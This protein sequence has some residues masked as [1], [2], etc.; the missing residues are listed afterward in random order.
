MAR[1]TNYGDNP[2]ST[3]LPPLANESSTESAVRYLREAK[4]KKRSHAIDMELRKEKEM[5]MRTRKNLLK[6]VLIGESES[7]RTTM[8]SHLRMKYAREQWDAEMAKWKSVIQLRILKAVVIILD[9]LRCELDDGAPPKSTNDTHLNRASG[10]PFD[11]SFSLGPDLS[12]KFESSSS[13]EDLPTSTGEDGGNQDTH[14]LPLFHLATLSSTFESEKE[15]ERATEVIARCGGDIK[16]LWMDEMVKSVLRK[17]KIELEES[18]QIFLEDIDRIASYNYAPSDEDVALVCSRTG[19][20]EYQIQL[21]Q[22]V[23][24]DGLTTEHYMGLYD[25]GSWRMARHAWMPFFEG[26]HAVIFF[27]SLS[28]F[29]QRSLQDPKVNR[30]EDSFIHWR[31][32]CESRLLKRSNLILFL[33]KCDVLRRKLQA[34]VKVKDYVPSYGDRP[35]HFDMVVKY[36]Q[37]PFTQIAKVYSDKKCFRQV[38]CLV[39]S[40][41]TTDAGLAIF[42]VKD[43]V[44]RGYL[45]KGNLL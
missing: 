27:A 29:D 42:I 8:V 34:G 31:A 6:A 13:G 12:G 44:L 20:Q 22:T 10:Y 19:I 30:L 16:I 40:V 26:I 1:D 14:W 2:F 33:T 7:G 39:S 3:F 18:A 41:A 43:A 4:D 21:E 9:A 23:D 36:F 5:L 45:K 37:F 35:N 11:P 28:D 24:S 38:H 32:I 25:I 15:R 17:R